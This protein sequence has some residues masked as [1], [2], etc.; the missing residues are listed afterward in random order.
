MLNFRN[1]IL[2]AFGVSSAAALIYEIVWLKALAYVFGTTA[3]ALSSVISIF[4]AGLAI[5]S[6]V[7]GTVGS[8]D[9]KFFAKMEIL[10]G[11]YGIFSVL[12]FPLLQKIYILLSGGILSA[13][14]ISTIVLLI[15]TV[16]IG[17]TFTIAGRLLSKY[18]TLG[19][20]IGK[21]YSADVVGSAI[22]SALA[23]FLLLPI[24]GITISIAIAAL[25]NFISAAILWGGKNE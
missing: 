24:V 17:A 3:Y 15:P 19:S 18:E 12:F 9:S 8:N 5:G 2:L 23:G 16:M 6:W 25:L 14:L 22:G 21:T 20:D 13:M 10:L 11:F 1:G 7:A 4:L